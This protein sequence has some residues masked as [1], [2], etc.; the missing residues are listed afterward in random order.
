MDEDQRLAALRQYRILDTDPEAQF[1]RV[2]EIARRQFG[3]PVA[4]VAFMDSNRNFL[5]ARGALPMSESPRDISFCGH[6]IL[7]DEVLVVDDATK[8]AR[9]AESPLVCAGPQVRFYAGAP[10]ITPS[11][12]RIGTVCLFDMKPRDDFGDVECEKLKDLAAIVVDHLEMRMIVGNVHDEIET[13][14]AAEREARRLAYHDALTGLPNRAYLQDVLD[15][16]PSTDG[17]AAVLYVDVDNLKLLNDAGGHGAGDEFLRETAAMLKERAGPEAFVARVDG[18][19][20]VVVLACKTKAEIEALATSLVADISRLRTID[21]HAV[22]I[23]LSVGIAYADVAGDGPNGMFRRA[24]LALRAAKNTGR[25]H[26]SVFNETMASSADRRRRLELDLD[27]A[28]RSGGVTVHY[29]PIHH[30]VDRRIVG[31]E[32]LAR[33]EHPQLGPISPLEFIGIAE[34]NGRILELGEQIMRT[35][36]RDGAMWQDLF[37]SV[38]L[39]VAQFRQ[40]NLAHCIGAI[41]AETGFA[42]ER[43]ELEVTES[44]FLHDV[45]TARQQIETLR[46]LG[47]KTAL[48]DFGTGYSS[49]SYL[50]SIPFDKVKIDRAFVTGISRQRANHAIIQCI[51]ALAREL[52]MSVTA[53]GV[54]DEGELL[55]LQAAGCNLIQG[56]Y[57]GRP[58][59]AADITDLLVAR[60]PALRIA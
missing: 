6:T 52:D 53:E 35:A 5:K 50:Q 37:L 42:P 45:D 3:V 26:I 24:D 58:M 16:P 54:E 60:T 19:E 49:L 29:Q 11:G 34:E 10:L 39:S 22:S 25:N 46:A 12:Q 18:D 33:W 48:D 40:P 32:A 17:C 47:V 44:V 36:L 14:R 9:F 55:L 27:A 2:A 1:D 43:L 8:D 28:I 23:G 15:R 57:F 59:P 21:G 7:A 13:R 41:M 56:Y 20:F 30:A 38:N 4:L 51:V 31:V